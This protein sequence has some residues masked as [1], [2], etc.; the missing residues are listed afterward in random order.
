MLARGWV[1]KQPVDELVVR[2]GVI[3]NVRHDERSNVWALVLAQVAS[4]VPQQMTRCPIQ[5]DVDPA[6]FTEGT[7]GETG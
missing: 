2:L 7:K 5:L 4:D 3:Q 1:A 6:F